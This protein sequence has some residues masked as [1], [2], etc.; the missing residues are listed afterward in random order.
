VGPAAGLLSPRY[1]SSTLNPSSK[2]RRI[3][4]KNYV[5]PNVD[6]DLQARLAEH[7]AANP[8]PHPPADDH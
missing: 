7:A 5:S 3:G 2:S 6:D 4:R 1:K 8:Q